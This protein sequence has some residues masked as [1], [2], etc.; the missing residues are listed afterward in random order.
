MTVMIHLVQH[1]REIV[2]TREISLSTF[3]GDYS[4]NSV[5]LTEGPLYTGPRGGRPSFLGEEVLV[6][7]LEAFIFS[8]ER[9][10]TCKETIAL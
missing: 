3:E 8:L 1:F 7:I 10:E 5:R 9:E 4:P 2:Y 6:S